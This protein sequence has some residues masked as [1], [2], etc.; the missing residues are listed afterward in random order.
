MTMAGSHEGVDGE[1]RGRAAVVE[2]DGAADGRASFEA[3]ID[4]CGQ[5]RL[6]S[7][8]RHGGGNALAV[9]VRG[10]LKHIGR[11]GGER[12]KIS[13]LIRDDVVSARADLRKGEASVQCGLD[14]RDHDLSMPFVLPA[15][16]MGFLNQRDWLEHHRGETGRGIGICAVD[17]AGDGGGLLPG[18]SGALRR[19]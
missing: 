11:K 6:D 2:E 9:L 12:R 15:G 3:K 8:L 14:G 5:A 4:R 17:V 18:G 16:E 1:A 10:M 19:A 7:H 13:G